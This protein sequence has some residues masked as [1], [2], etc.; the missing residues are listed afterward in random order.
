MQC[1]NAA[2]LCSAL[3]LGA[4]GASVTP[5]QKVL[6]MMGDMKQKGIT[7]KEEEATKFAAFE[8]WCGNQ[9]RIKNQEIEEGTNMIAKLEANIEKSQASIKK[10]TTLIEELDIDVSRSEKE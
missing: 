5:I 2:L 6:Q 8:T 4:S 9:D 1:L 10:L 7:E 3:L